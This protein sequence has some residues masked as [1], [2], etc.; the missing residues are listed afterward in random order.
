MESVFACVEQ[1]DHAVHV[2]TDGNLDRAQFVVGVLGVFI[3]SGVIPKAQEILLDAA[4]HNGKVRV[5]DIGQDDR[6][7]GAFAC[8]DSASLKVGDVVQLVRHAA[9]NGFGASEISGSSRSACETVLTE[10][11]VASAISF[12]LVFIVSFLRLSVR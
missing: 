11:L 1:M 4:E 3:N 10:K 7:D 9:D 8:A 2:L 5:N 12:N 6:N